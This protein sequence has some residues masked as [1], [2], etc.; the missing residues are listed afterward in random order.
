MGDAHRRALGGVRSYHARRWGTVA[1]PRPALHPRRPGDPEIGRAF[2]TIGLTVT[3][4][5]GL[6]AALLWGVPDVPLAVAIRRVGELS[7]LVW[8]L[9]IGI[10]ATLPIVATT[11]PP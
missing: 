6:L 11:G 5:L 7:V 9:A 8:S 4:V 10:V 2:A 1:A 3:I